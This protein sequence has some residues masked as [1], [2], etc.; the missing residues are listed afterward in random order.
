MLQELL[1]IDYKVLYYRAQKTN[2]PIL[3][4]DNYY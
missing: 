4:G 3:M 2:F 1:S